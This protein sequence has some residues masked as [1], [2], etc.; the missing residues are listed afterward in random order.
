MS[1]VDVPHPGDQNVSECKKVIKRCS[2]G[3]PLS[4]TRVETEV[5]ILCYDS[6]CDHPRH[7]R[8]PPLPPPSLSLSTRM[9]MNEVEFGLYVDRHGVPLLNR[10][11]IEWEG[12]ADRASFRFPHVFLFS[13]AFVEV[14]NLITGHLTQIIRPDGNGSGGGPQI[15]CLWDGRGGGRNLEHDMDFGGGG[16]SP[17]SPPTVLGVAN[18][19][20][21]NEWGAQ[22]NSVMA[23]QCIFTLFSPIP[24]P[25]SLVEEPVIPYDANSII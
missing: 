10:G 18:L 9:R 15:R 25:Y 13:S 20:T 23:Q 7:A 19:S 12:Q 11:I 2:A 24:P 6:E 17:E 21:T 5:F 8:V 22:S 3:R 1:F 16:P 4:M 14:R